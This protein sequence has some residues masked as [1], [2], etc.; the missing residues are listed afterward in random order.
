MIGDG[1]IKSIAYVENLSAFI[2]HTLELKKCH[3][4]NYVDKPDFS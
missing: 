4:F 3:I 2:K 1:K